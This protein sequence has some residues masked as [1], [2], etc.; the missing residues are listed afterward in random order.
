MTAVSSQRNRYTS[1]P[2]YGL[3]NKKMPQQQPLQSGQQ[4]QQ[5]H[6]SQPQQPYPQQGYPQQ[7]YP[8]QGYAQ[9]PYQQNPYQQQF[10]QQG[11]QQFRQPYSQ[12]WQQNPYQQQF[13]QQPQQVYQTQPNYGQ[14]KAQQQTQK[15]HSYNWL[16]AV[17][18]LAL[19][20]LFLAALISGQM[21]LQGMF[22]VCALA[23]ISVLLFA[24]PFSKNA[25][26]TLALIYG[27]LLVITVVALLFTLPAN[28]VRQVSAQGNMDASALFGGDSALSSVSAQQPQQPQDAAAQE[29][30]PAAAESTDSPNASMASMR[31]NTFMNYWAESRLDSMLELCLPS[32]VNNLEN[33][34]SELFILL[35][36]RTPMSYTVESISGSDADTSRTVTLTV[37]I[38]KKNT[39]DPAYY[40]MQVLMLRIND[41]W[42][43][44][45]NSL[46]ATKMSTTPQPGDQ[47]VGTIP[48]V[49]TQ[50]PTEAPTFAANMLLYYNP[51]GGLYYHA[52]EDCYTVAEEYLPLKAFYYS[53]L[54]NTT[55]KN[56]L[57]CNKCEAPA[58]P[59]ITGN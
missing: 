50:A 31:L 40:Q 29:D 41:T 52:K 30:V 13:P 25:R 47:E 2:L 14:A 44:D 49:P 5:P 18:T 26:Y 59:V 1:A 22:I 15:R 38:D 48:F 43:V 20:V 56:L 8:Q 7:P 45:P 55:F 32:W 12:P 23:V 53:D 58:R 34:K 9:Q 11:G 35:A 4:F 17:V 21:V 28:D 10:P 27:A 51:D 33:P 24:R 3:K 39:S 57:A 42:Y 37:L 54:N 36:N 16:I 19:P 46:G 6:Q